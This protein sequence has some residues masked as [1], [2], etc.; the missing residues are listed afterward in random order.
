MDF[1]KIAC[2]VATSWAFETADHELVKA[3]AAALKEAYDAGRESEAAMWEKMAI[4]REME[5]E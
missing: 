4:E 2:R 3:I 1:E 5:I